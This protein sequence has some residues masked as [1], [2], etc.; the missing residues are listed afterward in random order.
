MSHLQRGHIFQL[1]GPQSL[2]S[3]KHPFLSSQV[4]PFWSIYM[5]LQYEHWHGQLLLGFSTCS[6]RRP[7]LFVH[8]QHP[9][10]TAHPDATERPSPMAMPERPAMRPLRRTLPLRRASVVRGWKL[11]VRVLRSRSAGSRPK[12]DQGWSSGTSFC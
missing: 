3:Q 1:E 11:V 4:L 12:A 7:D 6:P 8:S 5:H 10:P 9:G 2:D